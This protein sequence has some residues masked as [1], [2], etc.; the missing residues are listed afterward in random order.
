M[1]LKDVKIKNVKLGWNVNEELRDRFHAMA[2]EKHYQDTDENKQRR[3]CFKAEIEKVMKIGLWLNGNPDDLD[4]L[5]G[6]PDIIDF[7]IEIDKLSK[8]SITPFKNVEEKAKTTPKK[9]KP[10]PKPKKEEKAEVPLIIAEQ[11]EEKGRKRFGSMPGL[12]GLGQTKK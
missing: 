4:Y 5:R 7:Y 11:N 2:L 6:D 1:K 8:R 3:Y 10:K 9:R 12:R